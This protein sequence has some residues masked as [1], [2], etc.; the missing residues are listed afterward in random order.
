MLNN[1]KIGSKIYLGFGSVLLV[2]G[3][4]AGAGVYS[5]LTN[6]ASFGEYRE[7]AKE[8][9]EAGRI[10][11]NMLEARLAFRKF[12][13]EPTERI[14]AGR[15]DTSRDDEGIGRHHAELSA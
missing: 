8:T 5:N 6:V 10:Q 12:R 13:A 7:S 11:A 9:N 1:M 15:N 4:I 2:L 3:V 14:E